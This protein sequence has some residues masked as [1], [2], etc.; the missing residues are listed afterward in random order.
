MLGWRLAARLE[1]SALSAKAAVTAICQH[2][3]GAV[4]TVDTIGGWLGIVRRE[5]ELILRNTT[6]MDTGQ[7]STQAQVQTSTGKTV[8]RKDG[9][10]ERR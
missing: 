4:D 6:V 3:T 7:H 5:K 8:T 2:S 1:P 9:D 10:K